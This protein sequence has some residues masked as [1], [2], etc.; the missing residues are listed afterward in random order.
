MK[1]VN[2]STLNF[3]RVRKAFRCLVLP[4]ILF[5]K[6]APEADFDKSEVEIEHLLQITAQSV[7]GEKPF[8]Q[9]PSNF[10]ESVDNRKMCN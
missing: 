2:E 5:R 3:A 7:N 6:F 4:K 1:V 10:C 9:I 8:C